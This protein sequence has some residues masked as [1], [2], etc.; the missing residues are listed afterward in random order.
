MKKN[1]LLLALL[2]IFFGNPGKAQFNHLINKVSKSV[3]DKIDGKPAESTKNTNK[4]PEPKC[5]CEKSELIVDLGK[6]KLMY[7]E[8]SILL[9]DEGAILLSSRYSK[10]YYISKDGV[11]QGPFK[12]GDPH[13]AG[14]DVP[15]NSMAPDNRGSEEKAAIDPWANNQY[16]SKTGEKYLIKFAGK[17]YGPYATIQQFKV[18]KSKDKFASIVIQT[19][20]VSEADGKKMQKEIDAAKTDAEKQELAMKYNQ[21]MMQ[22]IMEGGGPRSTL[23]KLVTNVE[24][25]TY[26]LIKSQGG[27]LNSDIKYDDILFKS[28]TKVVDLSNNVL[29]DLKQDAQSSASFFIN[30]ANSIYAW[31]NSGTLSFS[32][33]KIMSDLF[34][35]HLVKVNTQVN[36]A[37]MYYSPKSNAIMQCKIPF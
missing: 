32:D 9:N 37:Y 10:D 30:T 1:I 5:A 35:P 15:D 20:P 11:T 3:E 8:L 14:F 12:Y 36:L 7:S 23:P 25:A 27:I 26:D 19:V 24:G 6:L 21:Q 33:N 29:F 28:S 18:N 16:I 13:L 34:N 4:E 31:Y 2:C 17:S 22:K